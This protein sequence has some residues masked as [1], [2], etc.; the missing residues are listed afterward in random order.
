MNSPD[1]EHHPTQPAAGE[2]NPHHTADLYGHRRSLAH[3]LHPLHRRPGPCHQPAGRTRPPRAQTGTSQQAS[4]PANRRHLPDPARYMSVNGPH[5]PGPRGHLR[6]DR[7]Q[8]SRPWPSLTVFAAQRTS[9]ARSRSLDATCGPSPRLAHNRQQAVY[10]TA[11]GH[12]SDPASGNTRT[13]PD[14]G[15]LGGRCWVRTNVG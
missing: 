15:F 6:A 10:R 14:L 7:S 12:A 11:P 5:R 1:C 9:R 8:S 4:G 13:G 2:L 3:H